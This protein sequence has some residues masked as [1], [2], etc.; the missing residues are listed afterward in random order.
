M[1]VVSGGLFAS[2]RSGPFGISDAEFL[3]A[4]YA[5]GRRPVHRCDRYSP[6]SGLGGRSPAYDI[7]ATTAALDRLRAVRERAGAAAT[8]IWVTEVGVSTSAGGN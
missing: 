7:A 8:P 3:S 6:I 1:P 4:L 5:A 2:S